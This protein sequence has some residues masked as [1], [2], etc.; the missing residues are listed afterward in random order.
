MITCSINEKTFSKED[1]DKIVELS[2]EF[3]DTEHDENQIPS[4][5]IT[6]KFNTINFPLSLNIIKDGSKVI[7]QTFILPS[8]K[9]DMLDFISGKINERELFYR[10]KSCERNNF[11]SL[12]IVS[13]LIIPEYRN[14][15]I[16][17]GALKKHLEVSGKEF[18][19]FP[20]LFCWIFS[21]EGEKLIEKLSRELE[22]K[23]LSKN[24]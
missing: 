23:I 9:K 24:N 19:F 5:E 15:G 14:K 17:L 6:Y 1:H 20:N 22:V 4:E 18:D 2:E 12:Y 10:I 8:K 3:F 11:D 21:K 13:A 7:G 16:A